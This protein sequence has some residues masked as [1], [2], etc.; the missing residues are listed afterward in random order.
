MMSWTVIRAAAA[1]AAL[2]F[3]VSA[4]GTGRTMVME[5]PEAK[6][7][8]TA[9]TLERAADTVT[10]PDEFRTR[11]LKD[12]RARLYGE[13][14]K[15]GPFAEGPGL[16]IRI[17]VVQFDEGNQFERWF[18]GG[19]GNAGEGSL[20]VLAEFYDGEKKLAQ[21]QTE[22]RIGSGFF[23]GSMNEA[24]DKAAEE[25]AEYAIANFR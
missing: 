9:V 24:V 18:W 8:F 11:F 1:A 4:C 14:G 21:I 22:G 20:Q 3:L 13:D 2:G 16:V 25:I 12:I 10:V 7:A 19:I 5:P 15:A 17:K 23:G 6:Q